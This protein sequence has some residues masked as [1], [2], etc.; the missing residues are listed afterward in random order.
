MPLDLQKL[1]SIA[2]GEI[3]PEPPVTAVTP[4]HP[5]NVTGKNIHKY[6]NV[7]GV[8]GVTGKKNRLPKQSLLAVTE[9][10]TDCLIIRKPSNAIQKSCCVCGDSHAP[11][12]VNFGW[13]DPHKARWYCPK[14]KEA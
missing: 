2:R 1:L 12:G 9:A 13:C 6:R 11:F 10:V 7:T 5:Q 3:S 14:H 4:L 8:T